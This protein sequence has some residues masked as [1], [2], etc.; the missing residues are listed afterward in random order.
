[1]SNISIRLAEE[2]KRL[3]YS[4]AKLAEFVG[5]ARETQISYESGKTMP[6]TEYFDKISAINADVTFI[7]TGKRTRPLL[8]PEDELVLLDNYRRISAKEDRDAI[9]RMSA[10]LA[11]HSQSKKEG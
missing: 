10:A 1:M 3:G 11:Y 5:V 6:N 7:F 2:R 8:L 4:Q 9:Q